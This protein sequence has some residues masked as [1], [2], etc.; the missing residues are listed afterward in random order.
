MSG[1]TRFAR[2]R[3]AWGAVL[4]AVLAC[5]AASA[6]AAAPADEAGAQAKQIL[7]LA[8]VRGGLVVHVGCGDPGAPELTVALRAGP[9]YLVHGLDRDAAGVARARAHIRSVGLYGPVS[10]DRWTTAPR[11][12]YADNLVNLLVVGKGQGIGRDELLRVLAPGGV[13][14]IRR[15]QPGAAV[16]QWTKTVKPRPGTI[17]DWSH[18]LHDATNNAVAADTV[19]APPH[20]IQWIGGP[21][22]ARHHERLASITV[23]VSAGGRL[24]YI[25]DEAPAASILLPPKWSLVARD[26][27][28][29]VVLWR[30]EIAAWQPHLQPFRHGPPELARRL[31]A[32]GG[33]VYVTLGMGQPV[34][35]VDAATGQTLATYK[36]TEGT[37]EIL[38]EDGVLYLVSGG[39]ASVAKS[40]SP[41]RSASPAARTRT[42]L[43]VDA[44]KG[45]VL[46][47]RAGLRVL[48][49]SLAVGG[50]RVFFMD[51]RGLV[52]LDATTG[53]ELWRAKRTVALK[54]PGW[55]APTVV[56]SGDV[57]LCA[58]RQAATA[59]NFDESTGKNVAAWLA[60]EGYPGDLVAHDAASGK[61]LWRCRCAEAYHAPIDVFVVDGLV[62]YGQSRSRTGPDFTVGRDLHTGKIVRRIKTDKAFKT[63]M[64]HHR[65]HRNRATS[66]YVVAGRT[67]VEF[68]DLVTGEAFRHHWTRGTCQF[69][70]LPC[71][72]LL[73]APPHACA[74]YI[75]AKLTGFLALAP[76]RK[77]ESGKPK[78]QDASKLERGPAYG[79][80]V[81]PPAGRAGRQSSAVDPEDW[82]TYRHDAARSGCAKTSVSPKLHYVWKSDVGG[83]LTSPVIADGVA[84][85]ASVDAHTVHA[86]RADTGKEMWRFTAGGRVD[87]PPSV[88]HGL[89]VFGSVDGCVYCVHLADGKMVWRFRAAPKARRIVALGQVES[90]WP[91]HGSVLVQAAPSTGSRP[92]AVA[93]AA[94]RSSYLDGGLVL[95]RL[96]LKTGRVLS[97][98]RIYSRDPVTGEQPGEPITFEMQGAQSDVLSGD[99][100]RVYMR[101]LAFDPS[102]LEPV[103]SR[104]HLYSPAGFLDGDW[105]HRT[106]WIYGDHFYSGYIGWYF[107]GRENAA[108]RLLAVG[109][110]TIYGF[111]YKP[112]FYR[113]A[114]GRQYHLFAT[115][116]AS[117]PDPG[118]PDYRRASRDYSPRG[119][120][121]FKVKFTWHKDVPVLARA[122]VLA[123][124]TLFLAGPPERAIRS[125]PA[126]EGQQGAMLV[127]VS[128]SDGRVL[129]RYRLDA[130]SVYDGLA[131]ARGRLFVSLANGTLL[132]LGG[133]QPGKDRRPLEAWAPGPE[134]TTR[135]AGQGGLV[136][137][138]PLD[139][140]A[141]STAA[142]HSGLGNDAQ[143]SGQWVRGKF[144]TCLHTRGRGRALTVPDSPA[145]RFG[146]ASFSMAFWVNPDAH[147]RRLLGKQDFPRT[148]WVINILRDGRAELVLGTGQGKGKSVRPVS[149]TPLAKDKWTHVAFVV[150]RPRRTVTC[151]INGRPDSTTKIPPELTG[152]LSVRG[153]DLLIPSA[154]KPF[155]GLFDDLRLYPAEVKALY[156][157]TRKGPP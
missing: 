80:I 94:G 46:W 147:E 57:V 41:A 81:K 25:A 48:P 29:G 130:L 101:R 19:V 149:K 92:E 6:V 71:N 104:R 16:P 137:H 35:A 63:T 44:A 119:G 132:C 9:S 153:K 131:A 21:R 136:G 117:L 39:A 128:G 97:R 49:S 51:D 107:A 116:K 143:V 79:A 87:S 69:G 31:V 127:A 77:A 155:A 99:G 157:K 66:R 134:A 26:A 93:F 22:N 95:Y 100:E 43:A 5:A 118:R 154:H 78:A 133:P 83:R 17:D 106:Y 54:R 144:G 82:P 8:G 52:G 141:G 65:C 58:D 28:N 36:G 47:K 67:G 20:H 148:W 56:V 123:K 33:R 108:G 40:P 14:C 55:S 53:R 88:S 84:L 1:Q 109:D 76:A 37:E 125:M 139:E 140:G 59:N 10:V 90:A 105:L 98:R 113:G 72:G 61:E 91:V 4:A 3:R 111:G 75:E 146:T 152:S 121:K 11:L 126:F 2:L 112:S 138:W 15:S 73:Y 89:A 103:K 114:T 12:P 115:D 7:S 30:R 122:M 50:G 42:L 102:S 23:V 34:T 70:T 124:D 74:C 60:R 129:A 150:D 156:E 24:F 142:D 145:V 85:V 32:A 18:A 151:S 96:D 38:H 135:R 13:A 120:G 45:G 64:P 27:F 86:L 62:W 110:K 68:I